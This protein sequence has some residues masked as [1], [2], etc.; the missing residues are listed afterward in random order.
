MILFTAAMVNMADC[1][2]PVR[3][4]NDS[5]TTNTLHK[6]PN[7]DSNACQ[8]PEVGSV[9]SYFCAVYITHTH[10]HTHTQ[11]FIYSAMVAMIG[12]LIF[13]RMNWLFKAALN[14]AAFIVYMVIIG[15]VGFC[16]FDNH[17]SFVYGSCLSRE[18]R[19]QSVWVGG[20]A[21]SVV[22]LTTV[23]LGRTVSCEGGRYVVCEF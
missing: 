19:V 21:L 7:P 18:D 20:I 12:S 4:E 17:D 16:L 15:H 3:M 13:I 23:I 14:L 2:I 11:Y 5:C 22:F 6:T 1:M 10:T 8:Y 9:W